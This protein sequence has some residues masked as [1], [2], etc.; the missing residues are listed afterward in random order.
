MQNNCDE[1]KNI[2]NL[3]FEPGD[4]FE[5][6][7]LDATTSKWRN[8]HP[9]AG[10]FTYENIDKVIEDLNHISA[11]GVYF[12]PNPV[13]PDLLARSA[14]R[15]QQAKRNA[16]TTDADILKRRWL[17]IDCDPVRRSG[18]SSTD[19]EH[20][21]ALYKAMEITEYLTSIG[22]PKPIMLD[23]GN[24]AQL[25]YKIDLPVDDDGLI[26]ACLK[27]MA[28]ADDDKVKVDTTVYNPARIWRLSGTWN[29]KGDET[30]D[31]KHRMAKMISPP[32]KLE[33]VTLEQLQTLAGKQ[34]TPQAT[35]SKLQSDFNL[36]MWINEYSPEAEAPTSWKD[37][38]KWVLPICPFNPE[39]TNRS[40]VITEQANGAIGFTCHHNSCQE[41][42]WHALREL[43]GDPKPE[44]KEDK[45]V[46]L[47]GILN[48]NEKPRTVEKRKK[49]NLIVPLPVELHNM[50]GLVNDIMEF[51]MKSAAHPSQTAA[52]AGAMALMAHLAARKVSL[53]GIRTNPYL[54][55]LAKSGVGKDYPRKV[56]NHI[57][58]RLGISKNLV[59]TVSSNAGLEDAMVLMPALLWQSDEF[60]SF[61][62]RAAQDKSGRT[63][64]IIATI[65]RL[66]SSAGETFNT[67]PLAGKETKTIS[68]PNLVALTTST[69]VEFFGCL[70]DR[71]LA[72]GLISRMTIMHTENRSRGQIQ[73]DPRNISPSIIAQAEKWHKFVPPGSGNLDVRAMDAAV[74]PD[75]EKLLGEVYIIT[76]DEYEKCD[77]EST[78][79]WRLSI[80]ARAFEHVLKFSLI[81]ACS[82]ATEPQ[83][84]TITRPGV[85]WAKEFIFWESGQLI[86]MVER[87]HHK[88]EFARVSRRV[89]DILE[90]WR[91]NNDTN[92]PMPGRNFNRK[93]KDVPPNY[94][95]AVLESL[96]NQELI[97]IE[98]VATG[99]R[100][101]TF[102]S[103]I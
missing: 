82:A 94:L 34:E 48:K 52:F 55:L 6:R 68:C 59:E 14:N 89:L 99:K 66:F 50:P 60:Y 38:R 63:G 81:Y 49:S 8:E 58:A 10:Y 88:N 26:Q 95:N 51:S 5:I 101:A 78:D 45:D 12:T 3:V 64:E 36:D 22:W 35:F 16:A 24:G 103:L 30:K 41:N 102:Y 44:I 18:I 19:I 28:K 13:H 1:I 27:T 91:K 98:T 62:E 72:G 90:H 70:T 93:V 4:T 42:D 75:A 25:M 31:R 74:T 39:H 46:D 7:C 11:R 71:M 47:S 67:R 15:I 32:D 85:E 77:K 100:P 65:L 54:A 87:N 76:D 56:N 73:A 29:R 97:S 83:N 33:A 61:L 43:K 53:Y 57:L 69:P 80:W 92:T 21:A 17:L 79:D 2:L 40:A 37:G 23:S 86:A 96:V 9:E 20:D 84:V